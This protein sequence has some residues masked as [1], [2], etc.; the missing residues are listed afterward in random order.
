MAT[1]ALGVAGVV[2]G[3]CAAGP[4]YSEY[5]SRW[6]GAS[7]VQVVGD[8]GPPDYQYRDHKGRSAAQYIFYE[9]IAESLSSGRRIVWWCQTT[10]A[11]GSAGRVDEVTTTG[12]HCFPPDDLASDRRQRMTRR[13]PPPFIPPSDQ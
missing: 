6:K 9:V 5:L 2:L 4:D 12:N 7:R 10:F 8:W 11:F 13:G 1:A 3:A